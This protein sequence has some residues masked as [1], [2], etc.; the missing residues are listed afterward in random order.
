MYNNAN[1]GITNFDEFGLL[2]FGGQSTQENSN[3]N[4]EL[5]QLLS[6]KQQKKK[7][8]GG[9]NDFI[10][11]D[12]IRSRTSKRNIEDDGYASVSNLD[13]YFNTL[14][15]FYYNRGLIPIVT[16]GII[17][18]ITLFFTLLLSIFLFLYLDWYTLMKC[19]DE[20]T[21]YNDFN[22]YIIKYPF[23]TNHHYIIW[24]CIVLLYCIIFIIYSI[25]S[26]LSFIHTIQD[27]IYAKYIFTEKL[28]ISERKLLIGAI[29][30][31]YD[32]VSKLI[33]LQQS[34]E[35]R[36]IINDDNN[37]T[38]LNALYITNRILR[39]ENFLIALFNRG[40]LD[41]S[42]PFLNNQQGTTFY[43]SSIEVNNCN[44]LRKQGVIVFMYLLIYLQRIDKNLLCELS[45]FVIAVVCLISICIF[46]LFFLLLFIY[47][48]EV[49]YIL[50]CIK[51]YV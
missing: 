34:G 26:I 31:D 27:A 48:F 12:N 51:L 19:H 36:I 35:Y 43:C 30:W 6:H 2:D 38:Q 8:K 16:R 47:I 39:K 17:E 1:N 28:G 32:I 9:W 37:H 49:V 7:K 3:D 50:L 42:V 22:L 46:V 18:L 25:L 23:Y 10:F 41:L 15:S 33:S 13:V 24:K 29:D 11:L 40:Y 45:I 5:D 21:C 44:T 14:Y 20:N 4:I